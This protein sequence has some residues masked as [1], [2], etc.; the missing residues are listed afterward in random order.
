MSL[1]L[2]TTF[3]IAIALVLDVLL[4]E[5]KRYHPLVGFGNLASFVEQ[6]LNTPTT[7]LGG[8][9]SG[10][11]AWMLLILPVTFIV[12][13]S[14][15]IIDNFPVIE[16]FLL[17]LCIGWKSLIQ[18][19]SAIQSALQ[20][21]DISLARQRTQYIVSRDTETLTE[22]QISQTAIESLLENGNDAIFGC[23]FWFLVAGAPGAVLYRLANTLDAMWGYRT[24]RFDK[25]GWAAA[26]LDDLL[27]LIPARLCA[28]SYAL[29]GNTRR[30]LMCWKNQS[31]QL[32][33]PNGGP[34]MTSGAGSLR[35]KLG[36]PTYY[37]GCLVNKPF[38]G[39]GPE[40]SHSDI[41]RAIKLVNAT[42]Y[43]WVISLCSIS[44]GYSTL[45]GMLF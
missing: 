13:L 2:I 35:I 11:L 16:I 20:D 19:V 3:M 36:G 5:P 37:H 29:L 15:S 38:F 6:K 18:H 17:Y 12:F 22:Q 7:L 4:G 34:V 27:N 21:G 45:V 9:F 43:L 14:T 42:V 33:S 32:A 31:R 1:L 10:L 30:A 44:L 8:H 25:F 40:P 28:L 24:E 26:K 41:H 23:I 39:E